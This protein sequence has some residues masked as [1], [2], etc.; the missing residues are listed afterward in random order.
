MSSSECWCTV[1]E[2]G[3]VASLDGLLKNEWGL[4]FLGDRELIFHA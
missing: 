3:P 4:V 1:T 2:D